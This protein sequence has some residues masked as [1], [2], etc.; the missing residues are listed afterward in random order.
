MFLYY[1]H[2]RAWNKSGFGI[3][4]HPKTA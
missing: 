2:E 1:L 3:T 4:H